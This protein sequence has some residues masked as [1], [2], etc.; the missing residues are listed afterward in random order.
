MFDQFTASCLNENIILNFFQ[1]IKMF[2]IHPDTP[3]TEAE[4]PC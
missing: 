3:D 2:D 4:T 1:K